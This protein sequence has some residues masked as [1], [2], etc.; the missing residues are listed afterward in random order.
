[1]SKIK[2]LIEKNKSLISY[3]FWGVCTTVVNV[4][5]YYVCYNLWGVSNVVST[6]I[7]WLCA[8]LFAYVTNKLF[9]FDSKSFAWGVLK[10]EVPAFFA[11]RIATGVLDVVIMYLAVDVAGSNATVW[12]IISNVLV[13]I[14]NYI[15]SKRIIFKKKEREDGGR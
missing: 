5:S 15:A 2:D 4:A 7:A 11:C 3:A 10:R 1:M 6:A 12:K 14:I 9:V 13:I 8:V